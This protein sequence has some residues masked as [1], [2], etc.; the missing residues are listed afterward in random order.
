MQKVPTTPL[1]IL[2]VRAW[3]RCRRSE[4]LPRWASTMRTT[5][6]LPHAAPISRIETCLTALP[7]T[8]R[9]LV[10]KLSVV[11]ARASPLY[12][13]HDRS[14]WISPSPATT[15]LENFPLPAS[16]LD[17]SGLAFCCRVVR[18][19]VLVRSA[20]TKGMKNSHLPSRPL[21]LPEKKFLRKWSERS[22]ARTTSTSPATPLSV[23]EVG[24]KIHVTDQ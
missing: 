18:A 17:L 7:P 24:C 1:P 14:I 11:G 15:I 23:G 16:L 13:A 22:S 8:P 5:N 10:R 4:A 3:A 21:A 6:L 2:I 20:R 19:V 12:N 9:L